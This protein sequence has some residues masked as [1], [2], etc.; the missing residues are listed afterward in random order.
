MEKG[1]SPGAVDLNDKINSDFDHLTEPGNSLSVI[2]DPFCST[3]SVISTKQNKGNYHKAP[4]ESGDLATIHK[5]DVL[6]RKTVV[7]EPYHNY[8]PGIDDKPEKDKD[9]TWAFFSAL[10]SYILI[11]L[12]LFIWI[13][14][15]PL[16]Y[17]TLLLVLVGA[18]IGLVFAKRVKRK[19]EKKEKYKGRGKIRFA[20][21]AGIFGIVFTLFA[22]LIALGNE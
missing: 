22:L 20:K 15:M 7:P 3:D 8:S 5:P 16:F 12:C 21:F 17:I 2:S 13:F 1:K 18:I 14:S 6:L 19:H 11:F 10:I 9:V 4:N